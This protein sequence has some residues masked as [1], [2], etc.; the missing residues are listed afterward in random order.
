MNS[1]QLECFLAAAESASFVDG[2]RR[3]FYTPQAI[4]YQVSQLEQELGLPL[5]TRKAHGLELTA[6]G[7]RFKQDAPQLLAMMTDLAVRTHQAQS[8]ADRHT[9]TLRHHVY[10]YD[11]L[12]T[13]ALAAFARHRP[14][15]DVQPLLCSYRPPREA[16]RVVV[17]GPAELFGSA[18]VSIAHDNG[19]DLAAAGYVKRDL[20]TMTTHVVMNA[21]HPLAGRPSVTLEDI[22]PYTVVTYCKDVMDHVDIWHWNY[23]KDHLE[24]F[25]V[26]FAAPASYEESACNVL[27]N[28][29]VLLAQGAYTS[30]M[31]G[32]AQ[33]PLLGGQQPRAILV[34]RDDEG[35]PD[36]LALVAFLE[37]WYK[38]RS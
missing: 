20:F 18:R 2:A 25:S 3:L 8:A 15:V 9:I 4:S 1:K 26:R 38:E 31:P 11:P 37:A 34:W 33:V 27:G 35:D 24:D 36:V 29:D 30:L 21:D 16:L 22:R 10:A 12:F 28:Q 17:G 14:C 6:G 7:E 19:W 5:F 23:M 32:L 13:R